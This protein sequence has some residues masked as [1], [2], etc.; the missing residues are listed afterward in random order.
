MSLA[1]WRELRT[2][3]TR[4]AEDASV[5]CVVLRGEGEQSFCAGA[6]VSEKQGLDSAQSEADTQIALAG[7]QAVRDFSKPL[8]AMVSGYC[9]G[10]GV[11]LA[12]GCD[13]RLAAANASF[14]VPASRLGLAY[15]Y[16]DLKRLADVVGPARAKQ[17]LFT[18]DRVDA[19]RALL[20]GLVEDVVA[21][22]D[23]LDTTTR[24]ARRIAGNAPLTIAAAKHALVMAVSDPPGRDTARCDALASACLASEDYEEGRS[25][26]KD[27]R[28]PVFQGR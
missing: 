12:L 5:R 25:A 7:L 10:A 9:L 22:S 27:K 28:D 24:M 19:Q 14:G 1:M 2:T 23:L 15:Y 26:F 8:I 20:I 13:I 16:V 6:D 3:M 4:L 11:A 17:M 18:A 21:I